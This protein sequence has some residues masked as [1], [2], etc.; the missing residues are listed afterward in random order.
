MFLLLH[1]ISAGSVLDLSNVNCL[2]LIWNNDQKTSDY[3]IV[4]TKPLVGFVAICLLADK[5]IL[6]K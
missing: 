5:L 6:D 3:V 4:S 2:E 1:G